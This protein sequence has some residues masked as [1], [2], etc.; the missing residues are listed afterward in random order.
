M[1]SVS[2]HT[3]I[4]ENGSDCL[5]LWLVSGEW[6]VNVSLVVV[7]VDFFVVVLWH[8]WRSKLPL[9]THSSQLHLQSHREPVIAQFMRT[10]S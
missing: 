2:R 4:S 1:M 10:F 5:I 6:L 7:R 8:C 3:E 9:C